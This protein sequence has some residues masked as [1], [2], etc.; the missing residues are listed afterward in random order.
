L[1]TNHTVS[2]NGAKTTE[3]GVCHPRRQKNV[4]V[5]PTPHAP[6]P[7]IFTF[8]GAL[9][10]A[11]DSRPHS[12]FLDFSGVGNCR[13]VTTVLRSGLASIAPGTRRR[14]AEAVPPCLASRRQLLAADRAG[15]GDSPRSAA[16]PLQLFGQ[17]RV[18]RREA[19][20]H[21]DTPAEA[22]QFDC[23]CILSWQR[24][25]SQSLNITQ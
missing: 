8:S 17:L 3:T 22:P 21:P 2:A 20:G 12:P 25:T 15:C 10:G 14:R 13:R 11:N 19:L 4:V 7:D 24:K 1:I 16:S 9:P 23:G 18:H 6:R 5:I